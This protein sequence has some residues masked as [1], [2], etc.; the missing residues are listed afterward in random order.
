MVEQRRGS[1]KRWFVLALAI[2]L[3]LVV[4][5]IGVYRALD[6]RNWWEPEIDLPT[7]QARAQREQPVGKGE[8]ETVAFL[9]A[10]GFPD[11]NIRI[12]RIAPTDLRTGAAPDPR[13]GQLIVIQGWIPQRPRFARPDHVRAFCQFDP[14]DYLEQCSIQREDPQFITRWAES[15]PVPAPR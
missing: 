11:E 4:C 6:A 5:S 9:R 3:A 14:G 12:A 1:Q 7:M 13:A 15:T 8:A 2:V 10:L